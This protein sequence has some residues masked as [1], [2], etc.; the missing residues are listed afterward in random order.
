MYSLR[1]TNVSF[2]LTEAVSWFLA[3]LQDSWLTPRADSSGFSPSYKYDMLLWCKIFSERP[4][5]DY[6]E[7]TTMYLSMCVQGTIQD[8]AIVRFVAKFITKQEG[9]MYIRKKIIPPMTWHAPNPLSWYVIMNFSQ[10]LLS[11][12]YTVDINFLAFSLCFF[13][14]YIFIFSLFPLCTLH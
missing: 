3:F 12:F 10:K 4:H 2:P 5:R 14:L 7:S 13:L 11:R 8:K 6:G 1:F 9:I